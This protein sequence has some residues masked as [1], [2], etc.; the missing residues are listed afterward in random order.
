MSILKKRRWWKIP[1]TATVSR[2]LLQLPSVR[3]TC[4]DIDQVVRA[5]TPGDE[6]RPDQV[7]ELVPASR[8]QRPFAEADMQNGGTPGHGL[9][10]TDQLHV[11]VRFRLRHLVD[12]AVDL[13]HCVV[14]F[15]HVIDV[16]HATAQI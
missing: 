6:V 15:E 14:A 5:V 9:E 7:F 4:R 3:V 11:L 16:G 2:L 10:V 12:R 1:T 13:R 8:P